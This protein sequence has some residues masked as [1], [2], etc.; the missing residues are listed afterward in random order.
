M[1]GTTII[2]KKHYTWIPAYIIHGSQHALQYESVFLT[3]T[4]VEIHILILDVFVSQ[5]DTIEVFNLIE[6][7][8][9]LAAVSQFFYNK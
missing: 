1:L 9:G 6:T 7:T 8:M 4:I 3:V 2:K 5:Q